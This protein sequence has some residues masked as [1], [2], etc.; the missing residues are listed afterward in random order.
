MDETKAIDSFD[1]KYAF[2]SNFYPCEVRYEGEYFPSVEHAY[3]AAKA[4]QAERGRFKAGVTP[5]QAKKLGKIF[6]PEDWHNRKVAIMSSLLQQKFHQRNALA[7]LLVETGDAELIEGNTWGDTFWGVCNGVGSNMLGQMLMRER[8][9]LNQYFQRIA[10]LRRSNEDRFDFEAV[11][12]AY[13]KCRAFGMEHAAGES[14]EM[15]DRLKRLI[16]TK[17]VGI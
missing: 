8:D 13:N 5:G 9:E 12:W 2:L 10:A 16:I 15:M 14:P 11:T 17:G 6:K 4:P 3:Q 1:G 7:E